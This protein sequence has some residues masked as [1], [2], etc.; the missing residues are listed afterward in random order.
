MSPRPTGHVRTTATGTDLLLKRTFRAPIDDVWRSITDPESTARWFGPWEGDA[1]TGKTVRVQLSFEQNA[2]WCNVTIVDCA[3]PHR[4]E[5]SMKDEHGDW[6]LE[7]TLAA[8]GDTTEL[9]FVQRLSEAKLAG[10]VGPGWEYYLD[11]LVATREG[12]ERP[13]FDD[14]YPAQKAYYLSEAQSAES[15]RS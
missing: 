3:A 13:Q 6:H 1:A 15:G 9:K 10:D 14:Y 7:L 11:M 12:R 4:L 5:L 2:P 8:H